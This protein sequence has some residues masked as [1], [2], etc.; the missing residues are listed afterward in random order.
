[1]DLDSPYLK[2]PPPTPP[3]WA[4]QEVKDC[5]RREHDEWQERQ[6]MQNEQLIDSRPKK[7]WFWLREVLNLTREQI[8][9]GLDMPIMAEQVRPR[10]LKPDQHKVEIARLRKEIKEEEAIKQNITAKRR[11][12]LDEK[13][14][15]RI[16]AECTRLIARLKRKITEIRK[17]KWGSL[18]EHYELGEPVVQIRFFKEIFRPEW[19]QK[20]QDVVELRAPADDQFR[21]VEQEIIRL[22]VMAGIF[23]KS[24]NPALAELFKMDVEG[25][26]P[27]RDTTAK[28]IGSMGQFSIIKRGWSYSKSTGRL[29]ERALT[30][31]DQ[32]GQSF[33]WEA[34]E[35]DDDAS[36]V[37]VEDDYSENSSS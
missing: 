31:F 16:K 21:W 3:S 13:N 35:F 28:E 37:P 34:G 30:S 9:A 1:M 33:R 22:G 27:E 14:R 24:S 29:T 11:P 32:A 12:D 2:L 18:D 19:L 4:S 36:D 7:K 8:V 10:V 6:A 5:Y 23:Q 17:I 26:K 25:R 20:Y 15:R